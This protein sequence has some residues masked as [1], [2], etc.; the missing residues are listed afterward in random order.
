M[1]SSAVVE[2]AATAG[3]GATTAVSLPARRP[4]RGVAA[5]SALLVVALSVLV[6][7]FVVRD[8]APVAT[9][10]GIA[11]DESA[12]LTQLEV[13]YPDGWAPG[14]L[15]PADRSAG[16]V[17]KAQR[18]QPAASFLVRTVP[19]SDGVVRP[20]ELARSTSA[21]L[22]AGIRGYQELRSQVVTVDGHEGVR[23]TY[24]QQEGNATT[25]TVLAIVPLEGRAVYATVRTAPADA[26]RLA[27]EIDALL[28]AAVQGATG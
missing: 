17:A 6:T 19:T 27:P 21:A 25:Q 26:D 24:L 13:D 28:L 16:V 10:P 9:E 22:A 20:A 3:Q 18:R 1:S 8:D 12:G 5:V 7:W 15:S 4:R 2:E 23:L 14:V 11:T